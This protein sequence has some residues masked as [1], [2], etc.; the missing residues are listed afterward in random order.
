MPAC[1]SPS[2]TIDRAGRTHAP[3]VFPEIAPPMSSTEPTPEER[4]DALRRQIDTIDD[5]LHE[6]IVRRTE[7]VERVGEIKR[8]AWGQ[9]SF[10]RPGREARMLRRLNAQHRG[11]FP[12]PVLLRLWREM[13]IGSLCLEGPFSVAVLDARGDGEYWDLSRDHFGSFAPMHAWRSASDVL[14]EV[15]SGNA[16]VGVL[17]IPGTSS[18]DGDAH[19]WRGLFSERPGTP[20][21][22]ARLPFVRMP[23]SRAQ[24]L[25]GLVIAALEPEETGDDRTL[26]A[27][28][29]EGSEISRD[30]LFE[31]FER[32]G[33]KARWVDSHVT[34]GPA[35]LRTHLLEVAE[36]VGARDERLARLT[37]CFNDVSVRVIPIGGY[38]TPLSAEELRYPAPPAE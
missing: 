22:I 3:R 21:V 4:L 20:K 28:E 38:A 33:L 15:S 6:L 11:R 18:A 23:N 29:L 10:I 16:T 31:G 32:A 36:F 7:L 19:W 5:D 13:I 12:R 17:P 14:T 37:G 34:G 27:I 2:S 24:D 30:R 35:N 9:V 8:E 1:S 26:I 25:D